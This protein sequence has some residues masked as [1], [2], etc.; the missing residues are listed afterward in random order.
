VLD[1]IRAFPKP[2]KFEAM[3]FFQRIERGEPGN[4]Y[5]ILVTFLLP[6][7]SGWSES[8]ILHSLEEEIS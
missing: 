6:N 8:Q 2:N 4:N 5:E 7:R 1:S 3:T